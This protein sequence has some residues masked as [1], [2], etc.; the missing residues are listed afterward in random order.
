MTFVTV[1]EAGNSIMTE[2]SGEGA[3]LLELLR[4][5]LCHFPAL[6][7]YKVYNI[8]KGSPCQGEPPLPLEW[9]V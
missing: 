8:H 3:W 5:G 2:R 4:W 9:H 7:V 1:T 6:R